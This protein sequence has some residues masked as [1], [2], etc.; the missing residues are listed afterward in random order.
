MENKA[1]QTQLIQLQLFNYTQ[2]ILHAVF[3]GK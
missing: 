2:C 1:S 3:V